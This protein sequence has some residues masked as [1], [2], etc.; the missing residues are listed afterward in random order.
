MNLKNRH[1]RRQVAEG[2]ISKDHQ[3]Y[4]RTPLDSF[5]LPQFPSRV[6]LWACPQGCFSNGTSH[7]PLASLPICFVARR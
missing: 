7:E 6:F 4:P 3:C 2:T 1:L 5:P